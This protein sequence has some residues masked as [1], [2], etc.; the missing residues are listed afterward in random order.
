M[1][2]Q[3]DDALDRLL[4]RS[5]R[6]HNAGGEVCPSAEDV[7]AYLE[8]SLDAEEVRRIELHL[9]S[10]ARCAE[11]LATLVETEPVASRPAPAEAWWSWRAWRWAVPATAMVVL[12]VWLAS[13][14]RESPTPATQM[15]QHTVPAPAESV[16]AK[17]KAASQESSPAAVA[18]PETAPAAAVAAADLRRSSES[19]A[20]A[21]ADARLRAAGALPTAPQELPSPARE[22]KDQASADRERDVLDKRA[23]SQ[24]SPSAVTAPEPP[25]EL[26]KTESV[27]AEA[28]AVDAQRA[29]A[30]ARA[31]T[32]ATPDGRGSA[33]A[34]SAPIS[35]AVLDAAQR[36]GGAP[37][38]GSI[39]APLLLRS[40]AGNVMWRISG[41]L[42]E[43]SGDGGAVWA[44]EFRAANPV[45]AGVVAT[46]D[47]VW[48]VGA[49]GLV[50]QRRSTAAW[51]VVPPPAMDD[52]VSASDASA[53]SVTV[54]TANGRQF[55]TTNSGATWTVR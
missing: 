48:L 55:R 7:A 27:R 8:R 10:C 21:P 6:L 51:R 41:S 40:R 11:T 54:R 30:R 26:A 36:Q 20:S 38:A 37:P 53:T 17:N 31:A 14:L 32:S 13:G 45:S 29:Q 1:A 2:G 28:P 5:L 46:D 42:I 33:D 44:P 22:V 15:A 43:R 24:P 39:A 52:L 50:L 16:A 23:A 35:S 12:G 49:G 19:S 47:T 9:S 4:T 18:T 34:V 3:P 25:G